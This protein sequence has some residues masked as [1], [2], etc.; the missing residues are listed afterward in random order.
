[1]RALKNAETYGNGYV[2]MVRNFF[3]WSYLKKIKPGAEEG[4]I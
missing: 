4:I 1:M 2:A 3:D